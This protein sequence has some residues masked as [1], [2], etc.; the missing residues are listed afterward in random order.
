MKRLLLYL[1]CVSLEICSVAVASSQPILGDQPDVVIYHHSQQKNRG[2][3][4]WDCPV[5]AAYENGV[6]I[7]RK[8]WAD[9]LEAFTRSDRNLGIETVTKLNVLVSRYGGTFFKLTDASDS[10]VTTLWSAGKVVTIH[11]NWRTPRVIES[12]DASDAERIRLTNEHEKKLWETLP[13]DVRE[14]LLKVAAFNDPDGKPWRPEKLRLLLQPPNRV[15]VDP[16]QWPSQWSQIFTPVPGSRYMKSIELPGD[17]LGEL[18]KLLPAD[19]RPKTILIGGAL[20]YIE[21]HFVFPGEV[22]WSKRKW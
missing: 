12:R 3:L 20:R 19:G 1:F 11:G 22:A 6:V 18:L 13:A 10:E 4:K 17:M 15:G 7:W 9:S 16:V 21:I 5:F 2:V 8:E 14:E